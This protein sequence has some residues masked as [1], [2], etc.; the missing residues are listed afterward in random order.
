MGLGPSVCT[1]G[2]GL[3]YVRELVVILDLCGF[4]HLPPEGGPGGLSTP[5]SRPAEGQWVCV[6]SATGACF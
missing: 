6:V 4:E 5:C 2:M 3:E 1:T